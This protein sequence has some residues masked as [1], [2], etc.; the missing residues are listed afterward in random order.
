MTN[1][2]CKINI[3]GEEISLLFGMKSVFIF[4]QKYAEHVSKVG[5]GKEDGF[6]LFSYIVY[7]GMCNYADS[8]DEEYP[9]Y[10]TA[11][12]ITEHINADDELA[13]KVMSSYNGSKAAQDLINKISPAKDTD[14]KKKK[15]ITKQKPTQ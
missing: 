11:Y 8:K 7:A 10:Q 2:I 12:L 6:K 9:E 5:Q 14:T 13:K 4:G 3:E 1:G 15:T